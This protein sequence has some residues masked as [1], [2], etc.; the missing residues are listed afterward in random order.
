MLSKRWILLISVFLLIFL[1][2]ACGEGG[3]EEDKQENTPTVEVSAEGT[4][5]FHPEEVEESG[6]P[7]PD[8]VP[9]WIEIPECEE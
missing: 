2:M 4:E 1:S 6:C 8:K 9:V 7:D 5:R 3:S